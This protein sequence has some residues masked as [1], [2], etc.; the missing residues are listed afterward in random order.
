[1]GFSRF[2][3]EKKIKWIEVQTPHACIHLEKFM[4][5]LALVSG[6]PH[7]AYIFRFNTP[8][9]NTFPASGTHTCLILRGYP[10]PSS[11]TFLA[12]S[13]GVNPPLMFIHYQKCMTH[14]PCSWTS[15]SRGFAST[16]VLR[17]R[18]GTDGTGWR[19]WTGLGAC[20]AAA[21]CVA[22]VAQTHI[23]LRFTW[24]AWHK[25]ASTVVLRGRRGTHGTGW[26]AWTGLGACDAA[27]LC[28]AGV[29]Q[30]H[31]HSRF[32]WQ[33]WHKLASTVVLR[34]RR[35]THGTGWRAW[36]GLGAC[37]A[38]ALCVAG[39][40]TTSQS[41]EMGHLHEWNGSF[42]NLRAP[43]ESSEAAWQLC[44]WKRTGDHLLLPA[45]YWPHRVHGPRRHPHTHTHIHTHTDTHTHTQTHTHTYTHVHTHTHIHTQTHTHIHTHTDTHTHTHTHTR[46][47][48]QTHRHAHIIQTPV[49]G[50]PFSWWSALYVCGHIINGHASIALRRTSWRGASLIVAAHH[51]HILAHT[52]THTRTPTHLTHKHNSS[53]NNL[54]THT[55]P[56]ITSSTPILHHLFSLSCLSHAVFAFLLLLAGRSWL[57]G[58]S[59][60][61]IYLFSFFIFIFIYI[62][63]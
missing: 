30:P 46:T 4:Y 7:K 62:Y 57:V 51:T 5:P 9:I 23:H 44:I 49:V 22:G 11:H 26:R 37:D 12:K 28:V 39:V 19:A 2:P 6:A 3:R 20:D 38:A 15:W 29:A 10:P 21:L 33:A 50:H 25:L 17:G 24:Q 56:H 58:L 45:R 34:G 53:I 13:E 35:G 1:M 43:A 55:R 52:H 16:V 42:P 60:P 14:P 61:L 8:T 63:I 31:I 40:A 32:T 47:H 48:T 27:A 18:R 54:L 41:S 59:G 36:T